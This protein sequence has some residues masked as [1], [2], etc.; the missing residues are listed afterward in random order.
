M[1]LRLAALAVGLAAMVGAA[2][3]Q[4]S[5]RIRGLIVGASGYAEGGLGLAPLSGPR[6]DALLM[7][8]FL[9][10][11]GAARADLI[12][13]TE[14]ADVAEYRPSAALAP[15]GPASR[16]AISAGF[17]RLAQEARPGDQVVILLSGHGWRQLERIEGSEP[18]GLD[19]V[20]L[21]VD[22]GPVAPGHDIDAGDRVP[23]ALSDDEIG[24]W[25]DA[26]R[27]RGADVVLIADFCHAG[28]SARGEPELSGRGRES[29][30]DPVADRRGA[31]TAFFAAPADGRAMQGLA[32][33]WAPREA[34]AAHGL[35]TVYTVAALRDPAVATYADAA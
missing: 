34:R 9:T 23:G 17:R 35:L 11:R 8:D 33:I 19:E 18:D 4:E 6:N 25:I 10:E 26:I 14:G 15:D 28:D 1:K 16:E 2:E 29:R 24:G 13:L 20:F 30:L 32:P 12:L 21:P 5:P 27:D 3:A 31:Y 7:A 22:Y